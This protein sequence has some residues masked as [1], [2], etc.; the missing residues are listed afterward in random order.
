MAIYVGGT[1]TANQLDDYEEGTWTPVL[2]GYTGTQWD[3]VTYDNALDYSTGNYVKV[4]S[5]VFIMYYTGN[6]DLQSGWNTSVARINGLPFP[7]RNSEP[8]YG[9][10]FTFTHTNCFKNSSN[11]LF[12]CHS[13]WGVYGQTY[14]NPSVGNSSNQAR[15]GSES[16]RYIMVSGIYQTNV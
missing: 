4:G 8:Y 11:D 6:F 1:G 3:P 14:I 12:D 2:Q 9:G 13:G 7:F 10:C 16:S 5:T 15:W